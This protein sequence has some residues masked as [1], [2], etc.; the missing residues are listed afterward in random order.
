MTDNIEPVSEAS[1]P[2]RADRVILSLSDE[3][4]AKELELL[5]HHYHGDMP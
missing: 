5:Y 4:G 2:T 3:E 1:V